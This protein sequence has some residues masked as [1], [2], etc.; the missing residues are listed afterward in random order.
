MTDPFTAAAGI[1]TAGKIAE[2]VFQKFAEAGA[3][4]LGEKFTETGIQKLGDLWN[5]IRNRLRGKQDQKVDEALVHVEKGDRAA[6]AT[7]QKYLDVEMLEPEFAA[8]LQAIAQ[9]ITLNQI[10][11]NS[12]QTQNIYDGGTGFQN[13]IDGGTVYQAETINYY[14]TPPNP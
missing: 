3:G 11:D 12:S 2:L 13:K 5:R 10:Q 6:L 14:G 8:E 4:K 9:E 7:L 1:W